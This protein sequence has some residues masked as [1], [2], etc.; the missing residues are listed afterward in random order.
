VGGGIPEDHKTRHDYEYLGQDRYFT[1]PPVQYKEQICSAM[2]TAYI[3]DAC[4][5]FPP[6]SEGVALLHHISI[7]GLAAETEWPINM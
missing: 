6:G 1:F 2:M 4:S 7:Q 5:V 3:E